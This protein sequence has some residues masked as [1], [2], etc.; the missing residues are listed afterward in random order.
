MI[1]VPADVTVL[2]VRHVELNLD[3]IE[4]FLVSVLVKHDQLDESCAAGEFL[5]T[6]LFD[7][8]AWLLDRSL[9]FRFFSLLRILDIKQLADF[10]GRPVE[11]TDA[12]EVFNRL[13]LWIIRDGCPFIVELARMHLMNAQRFV[14]SQRD[15][16]HLLFGAAD[17]KAGLAVEGPDWDHLASRIRTGITRS[18]IS[19]GSFLNSTRRPRC[20][21]SV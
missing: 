4:D 9:W 1:A 12:V 20:A 16:P 11:S 6:R 17:L 18:W 8:R 5:F 2:V 21:P 14:H 13:A 15:K 19:T 3:D 10:F 7:L